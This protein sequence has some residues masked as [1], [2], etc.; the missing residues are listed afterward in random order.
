MPI[1]RIE[2]GADVIGYHIDIYDPV[3]GQNWYSLELVPEPSTLF[4][5]FI[6]IIVVGRNHRTRI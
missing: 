6:G 2:D 4:L 1:N 3:G 5:V